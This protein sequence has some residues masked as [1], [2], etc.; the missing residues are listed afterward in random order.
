MGLLLVNLCLCSWE[1]SY[2][3]LTLYKKKN[4]QTNP[5]FYEKAGHATAFPW[6]GNSEDL[7]KLLKKRYTVTAGKNKS[8]YSQK[9]LF[10]RTGATIIHIGLLWTM[11]AGFYRILADDFKWGVYDATVI[12]PEG[13]SSSSY[14]TR[15]NRLKQPTSDNLT[16]VD[17]PF[18]LRAVDFNAEYFP[19]STVAKN[20]A[21]LVE[22]TD[23]GTR[24]IYEVTMRHPVMYKGYKITQ[25]SFSP[26]ERIQR[27]KFRVTDKK[28]GKFIEVDTI[29]GDPVKLR[30][31]DDQHFILVDDLKPGAHYFVQDLE[32]QKVVEQ[33]TVE[34][35]ETLPLPIDT[36]PFASELAQSR[37]S[38]LVAALFPNFTF[39]ENKQPTTKDEKFENPAV[40]VML[41]KNGRPNGYTWLFLNPE[42]Q[43][44]VG[45]PH[46]EVELHFQNYRK[47]EGMTTETN[48][49]Y[50]YEVQLDVK[51]KSDGTDLGPVW[52]SAGQ[53]KELS[54]SPAMLSTGNVRMDRLKTS[55][56]DSMSSDTQI[57]A[58]DEPTS[59]PAVAANPPTNHFSVEFMGMTA[60]HV[61]F[62]GFMK[63]PSVA[64]IFTGCIIIILGTLIAFMFVY[65]EVWCYYDEKTGLLYMATAVRGTSPGAH[66]EFDRLVAAV[67]ALS[68]S[69]PV[70]PLATSEQPA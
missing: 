56:G 41:F 59:A 49:L 61:T 1:K 37:Y 64:W 28:S 26:N 47:K 17:M 19:H 44:I 25:N 45:Q 2:I 52:L 27:G 30:G 13:Q 48:T 8:W 24:R 21:S 57:A 60:G 18:S 31:L 5:R 9:G 38:M 29:P 33:G 46:P 35:P 62:L 34:D 58:A 50:D 63:D 22:L 12:L 6:S 66:R 65:R 36:A 42:A 40:M 67:K 7:N 11:A 43:K 4:L 39:D 69:Q 53:L 70:Q 3:A 55:H 23:G 68:R 14:V 54:V 10:G 16:P 15:K 32:S 51:Q 20:F